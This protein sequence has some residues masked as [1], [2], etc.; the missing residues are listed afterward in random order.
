MN[1]ITKPSSIS[2]VLGD[3]IEMTIDDYGEAIATDSPAIIQS[4]DHLLSSLEKFISDVQIERSQMYQ[5]GRGRTFGGLAL[6]VFA[7]QILLLLTTTGV[8]KGVFSLLKEWVGLKRE[9]SLKLKIKSADGTEVEVDAT[10]YT[11]DQLQE[12]IAAAG[13][14]ARSGRNPK[15]RSRKR[16]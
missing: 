12:A 11:F 14:E 15:P 9:R 1:N 2:I 7:Q 16:K 13:V 10:G 8:T 6:S 4:T 3:T 5:A